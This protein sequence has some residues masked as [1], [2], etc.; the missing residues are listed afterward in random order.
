M[1]F[2]W[3]Q[4]YS[5]ESLFSKLISHFVQVLCL[6]SQLEGEDVDKGTRE[7]RRGSRGAEDTFDIASTVPSRQS[8]R[9]RETR[10]YGCK[11]CE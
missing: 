1:I 3:L 5:L 4:K 7:V 6:S 11:M 8:V 10:I 9:Q 2:Q